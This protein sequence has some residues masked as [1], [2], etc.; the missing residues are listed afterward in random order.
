MGTILGFTLNV[1]SLALLG[2]SASRKKYW[3]LGMRWIPI[4]NLA[5]F[6]FQ[7]IDLLF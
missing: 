3:E 1:L 2:W 4:A 7:I 5:F 6:L